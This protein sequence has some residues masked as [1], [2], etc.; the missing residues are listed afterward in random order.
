MVAF[1]AFGTLLCR[2]V[3]R[4][5]S[6]CRNVT[7]RHIVVEGVVAMS[8][9]HLAQIEGLAICMNISCATGW[10]RDNTPHDN[11]PFS[12]LRCLTSFA[13]DKRKRHKCHR[14]R[15]MC[16]L[17]G[18]QTRDSRNMVPRLYWLSYPAAYTSSPL[19]SE[20]FWTVTYVVL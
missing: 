15:K 5:Q 17:I 12:V 14:E 8:L 20:Q 2:V 1:F 13:S 7:K 9:C 18:T 10:H 3:S 6:R 4:R 19:Y 16:S 11:V